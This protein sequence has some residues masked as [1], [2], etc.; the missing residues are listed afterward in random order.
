MEN[1]QQPTP[2]PTPP[3]YPPP[4]YYQEDEITLKDVIKKTIEFCNEIWRNKW[5]V[6]KPCYFQL[7]Q[8][9]GGT[10]SSLV[11]AGLFYFMTP[12]NPLR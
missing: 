9:M 3:P 11:L 5:G 8:H 4:Y 1:N 2:S 6:I 7:S 10:S 12:A